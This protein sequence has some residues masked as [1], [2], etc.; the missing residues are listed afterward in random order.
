VDKERGKEEQEE[1]EEESC[2][3]VVFLAH[4]H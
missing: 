3:D 1:H 2:P 4:R